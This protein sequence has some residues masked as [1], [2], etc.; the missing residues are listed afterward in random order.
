MLRTILLAAV[1]AMALSSGAAVA[2]VDGE[3]GIGHDDNLGN[4]RQDR[5]RADDAFATI[6]LSRSGHWRLSPASALQFAA[7][8]Q[9]RQYFEYHELSN[10]RVGGQLR[11]RHRFGAGF[12]RPDLAV[13]AAAHWQEFQSELRDGAEY[14]LGVSLHEQLSTRIGARLGAMARWRQAEAPAFDGD[15]VSLSLDVDWRWHWRTLAYFGV[16][17]VDG[18]FSSSAA[19]TGGRGT[20]D[21]ALPGALANRVPGQAQVY[22][23]G[24][25]HRLN[26]AFSIDLLYRHVDAKSDSDWHYRK[27]TPLLSLLWRY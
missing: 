10:A 22:T 15:T 7:E 9:A 23:A 18:E 6:A 11:W 5:R 3:F 20:V 27:S 13:T 24:L 16:Q 26:D 14:R 17:V 25:N 12:Y 8:V 1:G 21:D 19:V 4:A 2:A